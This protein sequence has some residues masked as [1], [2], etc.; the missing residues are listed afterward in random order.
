MLSTIGLRGWTKKVDSARQCS[1]GTTE[2]D[3]DKLT[4][5]RNKIAHTGDRSGRGRAAL[6]TADVEN[7]LRVIQEVVS[8]LEATLEN[9]AP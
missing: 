7:H 1:S 9:H 8:A 2:A 4:K 5:R 6:T 3:L